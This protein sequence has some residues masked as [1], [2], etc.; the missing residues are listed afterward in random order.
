MPWQGPA[1]LR[2]LRPEASRWMDL[3]VRT[4]SAVFG[5]FRKQHRFRQRSLQASPGSLPHQQALSRTSKVLNVPDSSYSPWC[6]RVVHVH[7][8]LQPASTYHLQKVRYACRRVHLE[9]PAW[10]YTAYS[11]VMTGLRRAKTG[12]DGPKTCQD[13]PKTAKRRPRTAKRRTK[14]GKDGQKTDQRRQRRPR[15]VQ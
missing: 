3:S 1:T 4:V 14:D 15:A 11:A 9:R 12:Q 7:G 5:T 6:T 2:S 8:R 10:P 13:R